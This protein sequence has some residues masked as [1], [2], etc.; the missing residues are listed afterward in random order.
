VKAAVSTV[1]FDGIGLDRGAAILASLGVEEAEPAYIDG[2]TPFDETTFTEAEGR[3]VAGLFAA[4]GVTVR[5]VSVHTDLGGPDG[6][7][8]LGRRLD[9]A[10]GLGADTMISNASRAEALSALMRTL[11]AALPRLE[12]AGVVLALENPGHGTGAAL[13]DGRAGAALA[14]AI[15]AP[16]VRLNYDIGNAFTYAGGRIDLAADLAAARS[17]ARRLH[18]KDIA[19]S[20][21]DWSFCPL[22]AGTVGYGRR[23]AGAMLEGI[24]LTVEHPIRLWRP[25]RGD[26]VRRAAPP[27]PDEAR[28]AVAASLESLGR[29]FRDA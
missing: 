19:E 11:D 14:A 3:R 29:D 28:R 16:W 24:D 4:E 20:G 21:A 17:H 7:D 10:R 27:T 22:G 26:P 15:G 6:A 23:I 5:A 12:Q 2:Y 25:G 9:F 13:P 18:L 8:R 1:V